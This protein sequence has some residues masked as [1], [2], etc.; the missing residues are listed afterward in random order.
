M[1]WY[2]PGDNGALIKGSMEGRREGGGWD[3]RNRRSDISVSQKLIP[4]GWLVP[5]NVVVIRRHL[6]CIICRVLL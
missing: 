5:D 6:N 4:K 3:R 1:K 2:F